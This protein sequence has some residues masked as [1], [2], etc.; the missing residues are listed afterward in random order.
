MGIPVSL[1][2][3][4]AGA[5][6]VWAVNEEPRGLDLD[7]VGVILMIV[8]VV[9]LLLTLLFWET[10][11]GRRPYARTTY[12]APASRRGWYAYGYRP[13]RRTYVEDEV[14]PPPGPPEPP[15]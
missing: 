12:V 6:L 4:G 9:G 2:L 3:I 13:G 15:P 5:I 10:W 11:L 14:A 7:A 1:L 8:G